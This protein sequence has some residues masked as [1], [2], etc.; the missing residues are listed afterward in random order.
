MNPAHND[1]IL[2]SEANR[3]RDVSSIKMSIRLANIFGY[4]NINKLGDLHGLSLVQFARFRNCGPKTMRELRGFLNE[5]EIA[6]KSF[7]IPPEAHV[8]NPFELPI[9][10]R[11]ANL[12]AA[13]QV[14]RLGDL[15]GYKPSEL[16]AV[17]N[18]GRVT[19]CELESLLVRIADG[20]FK[21]PTEPFRIEQTA[22]LLHLIDSSMAKLRDPA[23][24]IM[25]LRL[26]MG[27]TG[28]M[29]LEQASHCFKRSSE[30]IRQIEDK[31]VFQIKQLAGPQLRHYLHG[32]AKICLESVCPLTPALLRHWLG[33]DATP[34]KLSPAAYIRLLEKLDSGIFAWPQE[35][36]PHNVSEASNTITP[37]PAA[38]RT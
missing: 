16:L 11:L 18:C 19:I 31:S 12:L 23:G 20:E 1:T 7:S 14:T 13:I 37:S 32:V 36:E 2:I 10:V 15:D 3:G 38:A 9:S 27:P 29:T 8:I 6:I 4:N 28:I 21:T 33:E 17:N 5:P 26:E 30:R 35:Q 25:R 22:E 34:R 24:E